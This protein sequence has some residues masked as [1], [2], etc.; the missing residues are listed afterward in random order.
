[1]SEYERFL[2]IPQ[3]TLPRVCEEGH[4]D[5]NFKLDERRSHMTK[6]KET[7]LLGLIR[8]KYRP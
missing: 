1:M 7:P 5:L 3:G 8:K 2:G 4:L 6:L